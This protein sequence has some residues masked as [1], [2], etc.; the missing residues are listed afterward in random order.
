MTIADKVELALCLEKLGVDVLEVGFPAASPQ[1]A[2]AALAISRAVRRPKLAALCRATRHDID[3]ALGA[4]ERIGVGIIHLMG[5]A[6]DIH[7]EHKRHMTRG[8]AI[9]ELTAAVAYAAN[10]GTAGVIIGLEDATRA[11]RQ[12]LKA[13]IA[14]G[15]EAGGT[16]IGVGDTVGCTTPAEFADLVG[17][18]KE[19]GGLP[20]SVHC[21][22]DL[23]LATA[24]TLAAIKVGADEVQVTL[25]GIGERAGNA[26]LEEV[27]AA[28][29]ARSDYFEAETQIDLAKLQDACGLLLSII[30]E[31][32][33]KGKAIIGENAFST[34]A[35]I[36]Q[37]GILNDPRT[38]EF[39]QPERFGRQRRLVIGRHS[40]RSV[41]RARLR[42]AG[43]EPAADLIE[44]LYLELIHTSSANNLYD[45][46]YLINRYRMLGSSYRGV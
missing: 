45:E 10:A 20:V 29:D 25:C 35:G 32:V 13:M 4:M 33:P 21:H 11:D 16:A 24:N 38:Y 19:V 9:E 41:L 8:Q 5:V 3:S 44:R 7:L 2:A 40:G 15:R 31:T 37:H 39:L 17:Y 1:D 14:A 34:E 42:A 36:H 27:A 18:L 12:H 30:G 26:A 46:H 43:I 22:D 6:S 23:G 28:I